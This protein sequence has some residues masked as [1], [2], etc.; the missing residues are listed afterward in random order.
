M[1]PILLTWNLPAKKAAK[2]RMLAMRP[3]GVRVAA[4]ETWQYLQPLGSFTGDCGSMESLYDGARLFRGNAP[5]RALPGDA[6]L[7]FLQSWKAT[8]LPPVA[9]K[10][11]LTDTNR[12]W[13]SLELHEQLV[14]ERDSIRRG[15]RPKGHDAPVRNPQRARILSK[16]SKSALDFCGIRAIISTN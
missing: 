6:A 14:E 4:V 5:F 2:A 15:L 7:R 11:V 12:D 13:N 16:L 3:P 10:A 1:T 8:G 9:L